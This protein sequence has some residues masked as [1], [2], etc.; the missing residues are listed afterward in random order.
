MNF[1]IISGQSGAGKSQAKKTFEDYGYYCVDNLPPSLIPNF[2]ELLEQNTEQIANIALVIDIRG[3]KFFKDL[4]T[5]LDALREKRYDFKIFYF[6]AD[7]DVL[8]K[9]FKESRR[10]HP[11]DPNGRIEEAIEQEKTL[12]RTLRDEAD[13]VINTSHTTQ[14]QLKNEITKYL[15]SGEQ[16]L[17]MS[18][19]LVSFGFKRG[20]PMDSDFVFDVR[21]LPNPFYIE[22]LRG[23]TGNQTEVRDYVLSFDESKDF[24]EH[25]KG[26]LNFAIPH[27]TKDGRSQ[28]VVSVGCTGGQHRSVSFINA[29]SEYYKS[30]GHMVTTV[31]RDAKKVV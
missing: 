2:I 1:V 18:L 30:L 23:L 7:D 14:A 3:G 10:T 25:I 26:L 21:F 27:F 4:K 31:H 6:E 12:L 24:L 17:Q 15:D 28:L 29:L 16:S 22:S 19:T 8:L 13:I 11:L 5:H 20:V 9:R